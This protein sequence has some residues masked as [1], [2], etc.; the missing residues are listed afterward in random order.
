MPITDTADIQNSIFNNGGDNYLH[1]LCNIGNNYRE[2]KTSVAEKYK[3]A[4]GMMSQWDVRIIFILFG[5][6]AFSM[7]S[8]PSSSIFLP[9]DI[10]LTQLMKHGCF[11]S[12]Q[13]EFHGQTSL[14]HHGD[15]RGYLCSHL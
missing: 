1:I 15:D 2:A 8:F 13:G 4:P 12:S 14:H 5:I 10:V 3:P 6:I 7:V 11:E 9:S